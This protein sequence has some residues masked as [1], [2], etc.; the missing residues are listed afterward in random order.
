MDLLFF[1]QFEHVEIKRCCFR[2]SDAAFEIEYY[3]FA[4]DTSDSKTD[5][6]YAQY[7]IRPLNLS[8]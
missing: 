8:S 3:K 6:I 1:L 7:S 2:T 4:V 5:G